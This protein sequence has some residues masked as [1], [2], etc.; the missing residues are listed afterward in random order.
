MA[1]PCIAPQ[2]EPPVEKETLQVREPKQAASKQPP[3]SIP[4]EIF[5]GHEDF[6]GWTPD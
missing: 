2:V 4:A 6:L 5:E 3:R 1:A